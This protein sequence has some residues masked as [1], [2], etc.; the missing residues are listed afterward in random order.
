MNLYTLNPTFVKQTLID[1]FSSVVWTERY[2]SAGDVALVV[3]PTPNMIQTLAE[4]TFLAL[5][6]TKEVMII[7]NQSI[8]N[9]LLTV[10]GTSLLEFLKNRIIRTTLNS[11]IRNW[12]ITDKTA[13]EAV[14]EIVEKMCV[15]SVYL[16]EPRFN[17]GIDG[18]YEKIPYLTVVVPVVST[19]PEAP[20]EPT[21][22][23][24]QVPFGPVYDVLKTI[25][26]TFSIGIK[27]YLN[28]A[29]EESYSLKF[30][31]YMGVD[32]TSAQTA[33]PTVRFSPNLDSLTDI[34]ELRSMSNYK[35]VAYTFAPGVTDLGD[36]FGMAIEGVFLAEPPTAEESSAV[37]GFNRRTLMVFCDDITSESVGGSGTELDEVLNQR[38]RDALANNNYVKILD[39]EV[40]PQEDS[41][42]GTHYVLGDIVELQGHSGFVQRARITE[43]IRSQDSS[44]ER[45]YPTV[46]VI[47]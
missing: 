43:Y 13:R 7:E 21:I 5:A 39:G 37:T 40:I 32:R 14:T 19:D 8:E 9:N 46:S 38:A 41:Q 28:N 12:Y 22:P 34:K 44:G 36:H 47:G 42:Y 6:G 4:G 31:S 11:A 1:E 29:T 27:L 3:D 25:A 18:P 10:T 35:N 26:E 17:V 24:I 33:V 15:S 23:S 20:T 2:S 16:D 45:A 30:E